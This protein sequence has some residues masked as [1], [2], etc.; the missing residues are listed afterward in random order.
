MLT[1][2]G[3]RPASWAAAIP[4]RTLATGKSTPFIA[5]KTASSSESRLTVTRRSPAS[6]S[7]GG[8]LPQGGAVRRQRQVELAAVRPAERRQHRDE[9]RQVAPDERLA[10]RDPELLDAELDERPRDPLDLLEASAPRPSRQER[11]VRPEDLLRHA[12]RAAEVA[13]IRDRDA[14]VVQ[15]PAE[16]VLDGVLARA[17]SR[18]GRRGS[19]LLKPRFCARGDAITAADSPAARRPPPTH[20]Y[21]WDALVVPLADSTTPT[22][23]RTMPTRPGHPAVSGEAPSPWPRPTPARASGSPGA[24]SDPTS[25]RPR[26]IRPATARP[27]LR[28][29]G[30]RPTPPPRAARRRPSSRPIP[31]GA[32]PAPP[33][34]GARPRRSPRPPRRRRPRPRSPASSSPTSR[35]RCRPPRRRSGTRT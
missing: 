31:A 27:T 7:A 20:P 34:S 14:E 5:A 16:E 23:Q 13:A 9:D 3:S 11:E 4:S 25:N 22:T 17:R 6:R 24:R 8:E 28:P 10:A 21:H 29:A 30:P 12:V 26:P 19:I 1:F 2:T 33:P 35:R 32:R 18:R 15:R